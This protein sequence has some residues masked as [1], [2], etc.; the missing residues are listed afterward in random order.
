MSL[1][2]PARADLPTFNPFEPGLRRRPVPA[3]PPSS[4]SHEPGPADAVRP[5]GALPLRRRVRLLRDPT[6]SVED[7]SVVGRQPAGRAAGA[8][9]RRPAAAGHPQHPQPRP[10]RPHPHP[11]A[12]PAGVHARGRSSSST[13]RVQALVDDALDAVV[14]RGD[15]HGR[16]RRP[17][18]P[19]AV[20]GDLRDARHAGR[21]PRRSCASWAHTLTLG[22]EP[23]LAQLHMDEIVDASDHMIEHVL[24]AIEWK[25]AHPADDLLTALIDAEDDG[26]RLSARRARSTRWSCSSSPAT[27]RP[28]TSS[29]TARYALLRNRAQLERWQRR[30]VA[31]R[32]RGRRAAALRLRRCSSRGGSPPSTLEI[33]GRTIE[34]GRVRAHRARRRP[35]ATPRTGATTPTGAR[36]HPPRRGAAP[37][38]RRRASTT[39]SAPRWPG[40]RGGSPS[41]R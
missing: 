10:A 23:L 17:R 5:V 2:R 15:E 14:A 25:R 27:R 41:A 7:R 6:L 3:V 26:D 16:D 37:R 39:A 4:S 22:L 12:R 36:P 33:G 38:V 9:P 40:S 1:Y 21:R 28:S 29:A 19:A 18:V 31:R 20:P 30:P 34:R 8:G 11:R 24:D 35:T 13:P 32:Q